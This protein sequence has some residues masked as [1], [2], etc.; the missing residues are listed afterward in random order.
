MLLLLENKLPGENTSGL[1]QLICGHQ[2]ILYYS[3]WWAYVFPLESLTIP[4]LCFLISLTFCKAMTAVNPIFISLTC[5]LMKP[6]PGCAPYNLIILFPYNWMTDLW[7]N[8][9][10]PYGFLI[11]FFFF[12]SNFPFCLVLKSLL[13]LTQSWCTPSWENGRIR[14]LTSM[15]DSKVLPADLG[16][17]TINIKLL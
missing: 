9:Q 12:S 8:I 11:Y 14:W 17:A 15:G 1:T 13:R 2:F 16:L 6:G 3:I 10:P 4:Q 5:I 7:F